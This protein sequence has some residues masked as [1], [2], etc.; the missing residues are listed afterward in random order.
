M[1]STGMMFGRKFSTDVDSDV[2]E[3]VLSAVS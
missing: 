1:M 2:I 3:R